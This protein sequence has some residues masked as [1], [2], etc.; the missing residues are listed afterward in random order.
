MFL[1]QGNSFP[2]ASALALKELTGSLITLP[3]DILGFEY[4]KA[5]VFNNYSIKAHCLKELLIFTQK[6]QKII[7]L[8]HL[9]YVN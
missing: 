9:I 2:N 3:N 8:L 4:V 1:K 6:H 7:L 5:I